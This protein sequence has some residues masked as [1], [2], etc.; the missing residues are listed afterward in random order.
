MS[1]VKKSQFFLEA[2]HHQLMITDTLSVVSIGN[3][4]Y[5][6]HPKFP[7]YPPKA[8]HS[9]ANTQ[10]DIYCDVVSLSELCYRSRT[11]VSLLLQITFFHIFIN[12]QLPQLVITDTHLFH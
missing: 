11:Y 6:T 7:L 5:F 12:K 8:I 3:L 4:M 2:A 10:K 1:Y 9:L